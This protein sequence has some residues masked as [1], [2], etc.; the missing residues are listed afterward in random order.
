M[1]AY[2]LLFRH[3]LTRTDPE[4]AHH[5]AFRAIRAAGPAVRA[6]RVA[7]RASEPVEVLGL[8]FTHRFGLAAG[9][10]K[11]AVGIDALA[12]LGFSHVEIG[13]VTGLSQ[14]GNPRPRMFRLVD[15]RAV[16]NR[17]GF[18]NDGAA[19]V[20]QRLAVRAEKLERRGRRPDLVLGVNI[21]KSKVVPEDDEAAVLADYGS[22]ARLLAPYADYLVVNVSSP[23]TPGLRSLQAVER[24]APLVAH[25]RRTADA[26]T[27]SR[28]VPLL[29]KIA[30]DLA[31]DDVLAVADLAVAEDLDGVIATNTTVR[32]DGLR[33][34]DDV[35]ADIGA[36]GLS[37]A[38]VAERARE[39]LALLRPRLVGRALV[40]VGGVEDADEAL[41]RVRAGADLVQAYTGFVYGGPLWPRRVASALA[42]GPAPSPQE[43]P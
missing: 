14:P 33:T 23:N 26:A 20:A 15:D 24:L 10:D 12:A 5:A 13:T 40:S 35:V 25:V 3:G 21:G 30:P 34:P 43:Q 28:R 17:M 39:V 6:A 22:S 4:Q 27:G 42:D 38:P 19:A 8:R 9:F 36:G 16:V 7:P 31:D 29:V 2:D 41:A 32:R 11:N 1:G 37:G 18:N